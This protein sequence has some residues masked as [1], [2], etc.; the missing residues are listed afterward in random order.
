MP[1]DPEAIIS[2]L[3]I[4]L[5]TPTPTG[6]PPTDANPWVSQT[7]YNPTE[8]VSQSVFVQNIIAKHQE[9]SPTT[10]FSAMKQLANGTER[11]IYELTL[12]KDCIRTFEKANEALSKRRRAKRIRIQDGGT[13]TG[14]AAQI[15]IAEKEAKRSKRQKRS[16]EEGNEKVGLS[17]PRRCGNCGKIGHN[18]RTCQKV[19]ETSD[20]GSYIKSD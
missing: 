15:L 5:R 1:F 2:K 19:E 6:P 16:S 17:A 8:A 13:C 12:I 4:K 11:I 14:D 7:P 10:I 9:S 20:E 3:D 18:V